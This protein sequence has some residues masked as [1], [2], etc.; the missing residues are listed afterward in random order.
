M[1]DIWNYD[2]DKV[3]LI[4]LYRYKLLRSG[5]LKGLQNGL[6]I[7][8]RNNIKSPTCPPHHYM[9]GMHRKLVTEVTDYMEKQIDIHCKLNTEMDNYIE[10]LSKYSNSQ[11]Q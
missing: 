11:T 4:D 7:M 2:V 5:Y 9:N 3:S 8:H 6:D 1:E 10:A